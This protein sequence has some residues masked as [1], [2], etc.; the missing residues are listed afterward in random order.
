MNNDKILETL[1]P[2]SSFNFNKKIIIIQK[3]KY[4]NLYYKIA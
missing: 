4:Y 2:L 3:M 1:M